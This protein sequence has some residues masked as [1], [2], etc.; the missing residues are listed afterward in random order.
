MRAL[1]GK[2]A[3][4][5]VRSSQDML[6]R[7]HDLAGVS[8]VPPYLKAVLC[9]AGW[10]RTPGLDPNERDSSISPRSGTVTGGGCMAARRVV[11]PRRPGY[12]TIVVP[13][14]APRSILERRT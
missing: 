11:G 13:S 9:I 14:A 4:L 6:T 7:E 3:P 5:S 1:T 8:R 2:Q 10:D 12:R